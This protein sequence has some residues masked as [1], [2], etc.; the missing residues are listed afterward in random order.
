MMR[1]SEEEAK[2]IAERLNYRWPDRTVVAVAQEY[3]SG[4]VLMVASMNKEAV[5]KTLT[6]G[7]VHYWSK[8][9]KELW[10]KGATSG[11]VQVLE[12][13]YYDCDADSVLLVVRQASLIACHEGYRSCFHYKVEEGGVKVEEPSYE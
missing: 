6:T 4:K 8:S 12:K 2:R 3:K 9:R 5:I 13:F 1:V 11:H 7:I 10:V